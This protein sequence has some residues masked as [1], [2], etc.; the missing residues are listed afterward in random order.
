MRKTPMVAVCA[1]TRQ[2]SAVSRCS[3]G[4]EAALSVGRADGR[5]RA[6]L[7]SMFTQAPLSRTAPPRP[8]SP[9]T[10]EPAAFGSWPALAPAVLRFGGRLADGD[11]IALG[12]MVNFFGTD[13]LLGGS[14]NGGIGGRPYNMTSIGCHEP[15]WQTRRSY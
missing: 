2:N 5:R 1:A 3:S 7:G 15:A 10:I 13:R 14:T 8:Y 4:S 9:P 12:K 11:Q 6:I